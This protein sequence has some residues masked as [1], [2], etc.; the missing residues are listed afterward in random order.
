MLRKM[1]AY[2]FV[3]VES[4]GYAGGRLVVSAG[5]TIAAIS[6]EEQDGIPGPATTRAWDVVAGFDA[7]TLSR[8]MSVCQAFAS[9]DEER[10]RLN[11]VAFHD[12]RCAATDGTV[13][14]RMDFEGEQG[15]LSPFVI[16]VPAARL[17]NALRR[18]GEVK[19]MR[20]DPHTPRL[21]WE[22]EGAVVE[23]RE[24]FSF[25]EFPAYARVL[26]KYPPACVLEVDRN[27]L[28]EA[29]DRCRLVSKQVLMTLKSEGVLHLE[30]KD[31]EGGRVDEDIACTYTAI[32]GGWQGPIGVDPAYLLQ[33]VNHMPR[34][35][36]I[37]VRGPLAPILIDIEGGLAVVMPVRLD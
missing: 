33:A 35:G 37:E 36:R 18:D 1:S 13:L 10:H 11:G 2:T 8:H 21:R 27:A 32:R 34:K 23:L 26:P 15:T 31:Y 16:P 3:Q 4:E 12:S 24:P 19:V 25:S 9:K 17:L 6:A 29:L 14:A 28:R 30:S 5:K 20:E 22:L 7:K